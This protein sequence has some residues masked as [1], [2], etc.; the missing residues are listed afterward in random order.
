MVKVTKRAYNI[1]EPYII[2]EVITFNKA[3]EILNHIKK[4]FVKDIVTT[5]ETVWDIPTITTIYADYKYT[6][7]FTK[8]QQ[9]K[10][11]PFLREL[12]NGKPIKRNL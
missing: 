6:F 2:D 1:C 10:I 4:C 5:Y 8:K 12:N 3:I 11:E 9:K 7:Q